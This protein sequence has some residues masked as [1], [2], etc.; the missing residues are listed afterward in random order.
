MCKR[1][2]THNADTIQP[3]KFIS[4]PTLKKVLFF[5]WP[6]QRISIAKKNLQYTCYS[7]S[8]IIYFHFVLIQNE[9]KI[10]KKISYQRS[11][12]EKCC[13]TASI[14]ENRDYIKAQD[15]G[16]LMFSQIHILPTPAF[17]SGLRLK[18]LS[19]YL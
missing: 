13:F 17:S 10:K 9:K 8:E 1:I 5:L 12:C 11:L 2:F 7:N 14:P 6:A 19:I 18:N 3:H 15:D 16:S 4:F